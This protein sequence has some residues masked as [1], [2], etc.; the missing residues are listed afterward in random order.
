MV[1]LTWFF[2]M[3]Y[4]GEAVAQYT[5]VLDKPG[6]VKRLH[7][8]SGDFIFVKLNNGEKV[9]GRIGK[10]DSARFVINERIIQVADIDKVYKE[11]YMF[12]ILGPFIF[13]GGFVYGGSYVLNDYTFGERRPFSRRSFIYPTVGLVSSGAL[14]RFLA[15][16]RYKIGRCCDVKTLD[17]GDFAKPAPGMKSKGQ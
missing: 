2:L 4:G 14:M 15:Y 16:R 13:V 10:L 6:R 5:L 12:S 3:I 8:N 1:L 9:E 7:Y 17:L 11:R